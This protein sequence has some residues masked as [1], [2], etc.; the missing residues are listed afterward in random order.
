MPAISP[1]SRRRAPAWRRASPS[2]RV[3]K[4]SSS[5]ILAN[6]MAE[7]LFSDLSEL[8]RFGRLATGGIDRT[9]FSPAF[10][11]AQAWLSRRLAEAGLAVRVDAA[12]NVIGRYGPP[13]PSVVCASH[14]DTVPNGGALDGALGVLAG[15]EAFRTLKGSGHKFERALEVIAFADE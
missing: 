3:W 13:G 6:R 9:A 5:P 14:I 1:R 12:G 7:T 10:V 4:W 11:E 15:L 2:M 8:A